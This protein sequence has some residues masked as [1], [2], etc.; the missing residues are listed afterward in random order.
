MISRIALVWG[1]VIA[2]TG[3]AQAGG[4]GCVGDCYREAHVPPVYGMVA[5]QV[6][7][8][9]PRTYDVVTPAEYR[10]Q[11]ETYQISPGGRQWQVTRDAWGRR[12]GCWV[13]VPPRF[14]TRTRFVIVRAASSEP[15]TTYPI[16]GTR[17]RSVLV[18][19]ARRAWVPV[20]RP[21]GGPYPYGGF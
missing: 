19:P 13:D 18:E 11:T 14:A 3:A 5:E 21:H 8:S 4:A 17:E 6:L 20:E 10:T 1:A 9:P 7:V 15:H 2:A 16:Y 12:V